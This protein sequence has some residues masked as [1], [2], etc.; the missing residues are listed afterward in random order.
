MQREVEEREGDAEGG[1]GERGRSRKREGDG[2]GERGKE[3]GREEDLWQRT[4]LFPQPAREDHGD[5]CPLRW[6]RAARGEVIGIPH[7][8]ELL[9]LKQYVGYRTRESALSPFIWATWFPQHKSA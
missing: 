3:R 8:Q 5:R 6:Y 9:V 4:E 7:S 2:K 1:R